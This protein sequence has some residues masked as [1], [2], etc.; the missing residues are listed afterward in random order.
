MATYVIGHPTA[1]DNIQCEV[2]SVEGRKVVVSAACR[3]PEYVMSKAAFRW[4]TEDNEVE[5]ILNTVK[6]SPLYQDKREFSYMAPKEFN[7]VY[8]GGRM[9]PSICYEGTKRSMEVGE[10]SDVQNPYLGQAFANSLIA[11]QIE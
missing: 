1:H 2:V 5:V 4:I 6:K 10:L 9:R 7:E 8:V 3:N 11:A